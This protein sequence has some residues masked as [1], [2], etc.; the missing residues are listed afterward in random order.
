MAES[1]ILQLRQNPL[2][3]RT[4]S[5]INFRYHQKILDHDSNL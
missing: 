1:S 3:E 4:V 2:G 5:Q